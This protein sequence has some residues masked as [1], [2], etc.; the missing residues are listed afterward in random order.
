MKVDEKRLLDK[1]ITLATP[2]AEDSN[3]NL[4]LVRKNS[5]A[6]LS[7][8]EVMIGS[9]D[10]ISP[11]QP[12][13]MYVKKSHRDMCSEDDVNFNSAKKEQGID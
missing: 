8:C 4:E 10:S 3:D 5:T 11:A 6:I 7:L 1:I 9:G 13:M 2:M 12:S